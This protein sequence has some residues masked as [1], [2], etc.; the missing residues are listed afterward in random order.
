MRGRE[1]DHAP[2]HRLV[3]GEIRTIALAVGAAVTSGCWGSPCV[4]GT[5]AGAEVGV[6]LVAEYV[7]GGPY[8]FENEV[9]PELDACGTL[10]LL[11][12][13]VEIEVRF[14]SPLYGRLCGGTVFD[15]VDVTRYPEG[16]TLG[17][18]RQS[19]SIVSRWQV[20]AASRRD[21]D[22]GA[23]CSGDWQLYFLARDAS[24]PLGTVTSPPEPPAFVVLRMFRPLNPA[25]CGLDALPS[26][27][28]CGDAWVVR[29]EAG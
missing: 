10:G 20:F 28:Y 3:T 6:S 22:Y 19:L 18:S 9:V 4:P 29:L 14:G 17:P 11:A 5:E 24:T 8:A 26:D 21:V 27:T 23:G 1:R 7:P 16:V 13:G 15:T 25:V 12:T 2:R